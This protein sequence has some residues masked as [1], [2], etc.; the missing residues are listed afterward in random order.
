MGQGQNM[1]RH[2]KDECLFDNRQDHKDTSG[3]DKASRDKGHKKKAN[4]RVDGEF[5]E[6]SE[7]VDL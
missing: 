5:K 2:H 4:R 6:T 7:G 3:K 1:E